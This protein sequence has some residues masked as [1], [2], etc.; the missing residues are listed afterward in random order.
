MYRKLFKSRFLEDSSVF[1][2]HQRIIDINSVISAVEI[3]FHKEV[4][5]TAGSRRLKCC[6]MVLCAAVINI[7]RSDH[8]ISSYIPL[9][10]L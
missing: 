10:H 3:L 9:I 5:L 7:W 2:D 1:R 8:D 4:A 6:V